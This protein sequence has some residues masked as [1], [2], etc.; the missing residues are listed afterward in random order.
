MVVVGKRVD[1]L[2]LW[3]IVAHSQKPLVDEV[4]VNLR[5]TVAIGKI[6]RK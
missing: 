3:D 1:L 4:F 6:H 2:S 5:H